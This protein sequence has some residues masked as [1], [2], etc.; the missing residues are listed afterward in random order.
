MYRYKEMGNKGEVE[1]IRKVATMD[2]YDYRSAQ[3][4]TFPTV[5]DGE[6]I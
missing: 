3:G 4:R 2:T 5:I 1:S 6:I